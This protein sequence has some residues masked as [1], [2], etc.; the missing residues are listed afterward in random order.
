ML[1]TITGHILALHGVA[2][3]NICR[4]WHY[5]KLTIFGAIMLVLTLIS[6]PRILFPK[7]GIHNPRISTHATST[8]SRILTKPVYPPLERR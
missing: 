1:E 2:E 7:A 4:T 3:K 8:N 6:S 5:C